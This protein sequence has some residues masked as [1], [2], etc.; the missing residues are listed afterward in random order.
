M[1]TLPVHVWEY[2]VSLLPPHD[3][4][5]FATCSP[6]ALAVVRRVRVVAIDAGRWSLHQ[7]R[8]ALVQHWFDN[9]RQIVVT[10][11]W[12][13]KERKQLLLRILL[14]AKSLVRSVVI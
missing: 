6:C 8:A 3:L 11:F 14:N 9:V 12:H 2:I 7:L 10:D 5:N 1:Q 13:C 4:Y